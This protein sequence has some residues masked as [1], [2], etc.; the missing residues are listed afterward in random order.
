MKRGIRQFQTVATQSK[1]LMK[2][3]DTRVKLFGSKKSSLDDDFSEDIKGNTDLLLENQAHIIQI[4][5]KQESFN[6]TI[7][8]RINNLQT[9]S[10][11]S[12]IST[13]AI[14]RVESQPKLDQMLNSP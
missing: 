8:Q 5:E 9:K 12:S 14:A 7:L 2:E 11:G 13:K 10:E 3:L 1:S 4:M 6:K